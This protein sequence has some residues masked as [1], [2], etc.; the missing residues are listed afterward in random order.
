MAQASSLVVETLIELHRGIE[1]I[2]G[3]LFLY[4][5]FILIFIPH[6]LQI[7]VQIF[8]MR[9]ATIITIVVGLLS[10]SVSAACSCQTSG[11]YKVTN[12]GLY[13]G[14]CFQVLVPSNDHAYEC[15]T[16]GACHDYGKSSKCTGS[17]PYPR[18]A[19]HCGGRDAWKRDPEAEPEAEGVAEIEFTA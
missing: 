15:S 10:S 7:F 13:C 2:N 17:N 4:F 9:V 11:T 16:S 1:S 14:F 5:H 19:Y 8:I 3:L 6:I 18:D 12:P